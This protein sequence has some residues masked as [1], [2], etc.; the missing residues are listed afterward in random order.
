MT[1][2]D[3]LAAY[4]VTRPARAL[5][6]VPLPDAVPWQAAMMAALR[7]QAAT[8]GGSANLVVPWTDDLLERQELWTIATAL[9]PDVIAVARLAGSDFAGIV[10]DD[11]P[12]LDAGKGLGRVEGPEFE[13]IFRAVGERLPV[14]QRNGRA[15]PLFSDS[16]GIRFPCTPVAAVGGDLGPAPALRCAADLDLGLMLAAE[17]G[18]LEDSAIATLAR[19]RAVVTPYDLSPGDARDRVLRGPGQPGAG[20]AWAVSE[21]GLRWLVAVTEKPL[22][23]S[24]VVGDEPWDFALGYALRRMTGLAWW[25]PTSVL[26]DP[27]TVPCLLHRIDQIG[28]L[29]ERSAVTSLSNHV[30]AESLAEE[31]RTATSDSR[32]WLVRDDALEPLRE[33]PARLFSRA[34]GLETFAL[35]DGATGFMPPEL[36]EVGEAPGQRIYW[37]AELIG[38]NWQPL[39]DARLATEV[40]RWPSYDSASARPTRSGA[41]YLCPHFMR[42]SDD[43]ASEVV[44]PQIGVLGLREQL[45]TI[46]AESGWRLEPSDKGQ[47]A[48]GAAKLFGGDDELRTALSTPSWWRALTALRSETAPDGERRGWKLADQRTYYEL[49]GFVAIRAEAGL[50]ADLPEL[51]ERRILMRGLVFRCPLCRLKAW[52]GAD[53]LADR[54]RCARCREPFALTDRGWQPVAEPQWRYRMNELLWQLLTH[55]GDVPLRALRET[56]G[57]GTRDLRKPTA[58][59]HEHDLWEPGAETP[60]E[61]D[62]CAQ[63]GP[64]LWI[65]EAK[66]ANSLG[67]EQ[68]ARGK[69]EGLRQAAQLLRPHVILFVTA[70]ERWTDR[71]EEIARDV[72]G[73]LPSE[74]R[75][76]SCAR[77]V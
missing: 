37:M 2:L 4:R 68:Q 26:A 55:N 44:R 38:E 14:L 29:A 6:L 30:A 43:M 18:D 28:D 73:D 7:G 15:P 21:A 65:G 23:V 66:V 71:T 50:D 27:F 41:A 63:R 74:L 5:V 57:I 69:L 54:L 75:F 40:V 49:A 11:D 59:L 9:D 34:P 64:E 48:E 47:Y 32:D 51:L 70:S 76:A 53:E 56:L 19:R 52:Y 1:A 22:S 42:M 33:R 16:A 25:L 36:P 72:L 12:L 61:L 31:L 39:P 3:H 13:A 67:R 20:G 77:P 45:S 46:L 24:V 35:Q 62:I 17:A 8:W 58:A 10:A 60:I